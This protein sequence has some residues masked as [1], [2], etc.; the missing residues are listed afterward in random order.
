MHYWDYLSHEGPKKCLTH[1]V[2]IQK[3]PVSRQKLKNKIKTTANFHAWRVL[4]I[5]YQTH[6]YSRRAR[7]RNE[8][9]KHDG[10]QNKWASVSYL[11][12]SGSRGKAVLAL[13]RGS[14]RNSKP[15]SVQPC[16]KGVEGIGTS[17][18]R[19]SIGLTAVPCLLLFWNEDADTVRNMWRRRRFGHNER[20]K[21]CLVNYIFFCSHTPRIIAPD[22]KD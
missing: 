12:P 9:E 20:P 21:K 2:L 1:K 8:I 11:V 18:T 10:Q 17:I 6:T 4:R 15:L 22:S 13:V 14:T 5:P 19:S 16:F 3:A 7:R